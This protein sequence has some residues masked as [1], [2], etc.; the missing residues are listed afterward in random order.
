[1][2][3]HL[4]QTGSPNPHTEPDAPCQGLKTSLYLSTRCQLRTVFFFENEIPKISWERWHLV[5]QSPWL[6]VQQLERA[7]LSN[8][9]PSLAQHSLVCPSLSR[10]SL[11]A[12]QMVQVSG[13]Q[14]AFIA[15]VDASKCNQLPLCG[16]NILV[17]RNS[18]RERRTE[19]SLPGGSVVKK[20]PA[21]AGDTGLMH[22]P[23]RF[24]M[25]QSN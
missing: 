18:I 1:M 11:N 7:F 6:F 2:N 17:H 15:R 10:G 5:R 4:P 21:R 24:H 12:P 23:G 19:K 9:E 8:E 25:L 14:F 22:D 13:Q 16:W 20:P 3:V